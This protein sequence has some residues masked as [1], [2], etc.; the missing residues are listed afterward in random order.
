MPLNDLVCEKTTYT[1]SM[2]MNLTCF[3]RRRAWYLL[4]FFL[5]PF[6][7]LLLC[8]I[9]MSNRKKSSQQQKVEYF[10]AITVGIFAITSFPWRLESITSSSSLSLSFVRKSR[11]IYFHV[12]AWRH[13]DER[14]REWTDK[15]IKVQKA[16][17]LKWFF[18]SYPTQF[19]SS[20]PSSL[21]SIYHGQG[22]CLSGVC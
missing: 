15:E 18:I 5:L 9:L 20:L 7:F 3:C 4:L 8:D 11:C 17:K 22:C 13:F 12:I 21:L 1:T 10:F 19:S 16:R 2:S 6:L 14:Q